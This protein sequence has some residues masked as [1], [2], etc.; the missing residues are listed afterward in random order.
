[1][2]MEDASI[3]L[4]GLAAPHHQVASHRSVCEEGPGTPGTQH[5]HLSGE[6][7]A[8]EDPQ[9]SSWPDCPVTPCRRS[10]LQGCDGK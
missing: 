4:H 5:P 7:T 8:S 2:P 6:S 9:S 10:E 1:M 3:A